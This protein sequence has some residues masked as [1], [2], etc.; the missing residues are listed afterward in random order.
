MAKANPKKKEEP[1]NWLSDG[2]QTEDLARREISQQRCSAG[3]QPGTGNRERK[4]RRRQG[5]AVGIFPTGRNILSPAPDHYMEARRKINPPT[6]EGI[7][8]FLCHSALPESCNL[9][10]SKKLHQLHLLKPKNLTEFRHPSTVLRA[11]V[12]YIHRHVNLEG[13][14][15]RLW[16]SYPLPVHEWPVS[17]S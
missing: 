4:T 14:N 7:F 6:G 2:L 5:H 8:G 3:H 12:L 17:V 16:P 15:G 11:M 13:R 1:C 9:I 10:D